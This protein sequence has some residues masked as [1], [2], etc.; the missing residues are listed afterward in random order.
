MKYT[1][2]FA[3]GY[4]WP[5]LVKL[6]QGSYTTYCIH[7]SDKIHFDIL[8]KDIYLISILDLVTDPSYN[9]LLVLRISS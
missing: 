9:F 4:T 2:S 1:D 5:G 7:Y 8:N 3:E 6:L